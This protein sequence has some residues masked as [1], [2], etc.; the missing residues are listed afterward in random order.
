MVSASASRVW[1]SSGRPVMRAAAMWVRKPCAWAWRGVL[2]VVVEARLADA[3]DLGVFG[4]AG[5]IDG[6]DVQFLMRVV[7]MRADGAVDRVEALDDGDQVIE[8]GD[9]G[10]DVD[11][12]DRRRRHARARRHRRGRL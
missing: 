10:G 1:I 2:V 9:A 8:L 6:G 3:D 4:V 11:H 12:E 5:E 7:G